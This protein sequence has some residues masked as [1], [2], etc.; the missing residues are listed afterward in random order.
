MKNAEF[1]IGGRKVG[2]N[3]QPIVIAE[4]GINHSGNLGV[5][6]KMVDSASL[7]GAEIIK[8]QTHVIEDEMSK[9]ALK[10]IPGNSSK[11]I[12]EIMK[13]CALNEE[14]E[15]ELKKYVEDKGMLFISTP[16]SREAF[17]RLERFNVP[18]YKIG[19]GE[20]NNYPLV[21]L[22]SSKKKPLI[23]STGM[24]DIKSIRK[25]IEIIKRNK[26]PFAILHCTNVYPTPHNLVRLGALEEIKKEFPGVIF[27]L[28]DH[29][30]DNYACLAAV[31]MGASIVERHFTDSRRRK[32]PDIV[33]SMNEGDLRDLLKGVRIMKELRGGRKIPVKEEKV[34]M[35]F[36]FATVV[37]I[38]RVKSGEIF[39]DQNIW[40]KRPGL[41]KIK[42]EL[43]DTIIGKKSKSNLDIDHHLDWKDIEE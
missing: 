21:D 12:Y 17:Y 5:A 37:T 32:G 13:S 43:Y 30:V 35:D 28:S 36:A 40:V 26:C 38:K 14:D 8:H 27:G 33:C 42:A 1:E 11:S 41:G 15:L 2:Y 19:S 3:Y 24:N 22:I 10:V 23:L 9:R 16:F 29:S 25:S 18:A 20:C 31:S 6:K 4:I 39:S 7:A 34:T